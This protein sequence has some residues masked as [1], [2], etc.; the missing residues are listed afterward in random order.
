[1]ARH[2]RYFINVGGGLGNLGAIR[3]GFRGPSWAYD[4]IASGLGVVKVEDNNT[5]GIAYGCNNPRPAKVRINYRKSAE[6]NGTA[7]RFCEA[8][9]LN[10]ALFGGINS[11]KIKVRNTEFNIDNVTLIGSR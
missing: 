10:S 9:K 7:V 5:S 1:M 4:N 3:W 11:Q 8:D 6:K 2:D